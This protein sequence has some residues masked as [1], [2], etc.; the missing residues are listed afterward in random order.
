[1]FFINFMNKKKSQEGIALYIVIMILT[2]FITV[3]LALTNISLSQIRVSW[4]SG[5]SVKAFGA[6]DSG[7]EN[8][9]Y[10]IRKID[11][12]DNISQTNLAT[13]LSYT[14]DID[15]TTTSAT[16]QSKGVFRNVR[17]VI[18]ARY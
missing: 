4:Q 2:V 15:Y 5:D 17:R 9:L 13:D 11:N 6:A 14:V 3:V 10:N 18:E 1:M 12:F 8:A 7:V 16:I